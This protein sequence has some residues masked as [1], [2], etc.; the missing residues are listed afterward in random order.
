MSQV[1][2][3]SRWTTWSMGNEELLAR[4]TEGF[5]LDSGAFVCIAVPAACIPQNSVPNITQMADSK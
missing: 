1:T 4:L 2:T 3:I 5:A